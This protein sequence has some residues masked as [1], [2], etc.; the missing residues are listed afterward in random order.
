L[1][2]L[3]H[4][5]LGVIPGPDHVGRWDLGW[6]ESLRQVFLSTV[7]YSIIHQLHILSISFIYIS[8][9]ISAFE[10]VVHRWLSGGTQRNLATTFFF[11][12]FILEMLVALLK[13]F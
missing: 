8:Y 4:E 6:S 7:I 11:S 2:A 1:L 3:H 12:N 10:V 9:C 5:G 13:L